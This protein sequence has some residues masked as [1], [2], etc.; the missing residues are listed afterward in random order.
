[1]CASADFSCIEQILVVMQPSIPALRFVSVNLLQDSVEKD[2]V[3]LDQGAYIFADNSIGDEILRDWKHAHVTPHN[4]LSSHIF[5]NLVFLCVVQSH[6]RAQTTPRTSFRQEGEDDEDMTSMHT[7]MLSG[8]Y[9][10]EDDQQGCPSQEGGPKL[11]RIE[12]PRWSPK[13][14]QV[15]VHLRV[16]EQ[17]TLKR[18]PRSHHW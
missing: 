7:T 16:Q 17:S 10:V 15:R 14:N 12:T 1:M 3:S 9:G 5:R 13:T 4:I 11:I 2:R 6:F 18:T 8:W